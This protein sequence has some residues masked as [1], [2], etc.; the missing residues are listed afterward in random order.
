MVKAASATVSRTLDATETD[1]GLK[2]WL[3]E[4]GYRRCPLADNGSYFLPR[5]AKS[6]GLIPRNVM[7]LRGNQHGFF[8]S[9]LTILDNL[10]WCDEQDV[11][12]GAVTGSP[13]AIARRRT[14]GNT[15][16]RRSRPTFAAR[17]GSARPRVH[18]W[19]VRI[20]SPRN[21]GRAI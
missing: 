20:G 1:G 16:S 11:T 19:L 12:S 8:S 21:N 13:T 3:G 9:F 10:A 15:T 14:S 7:V 18:S 5:D 2:A 17:I 6:D 4:L